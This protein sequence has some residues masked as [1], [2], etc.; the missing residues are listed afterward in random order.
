MQ[1][2]L[3][4]VSDRLRLADQLICRRRAEESLNAQSASAWEALLAVD[5][6]ARRLR[7]HK[8]AEANRRRILE[9]AFDLLRVE[10]LVWVA[11]Q[12]DQPVLVRG[13]ATLSPAEY[14]QLTLSLS[15]FPDFQ[16][17]AP[18]FCN[19]VQGNAW[20]LRYPRRKNVLAF[21]ISDQRPLGWIIAVN[22]QD[23]IPFRKSDAALLTPFAALIELHARSSDRYEDLKDLLVGLTR[24]L[25]TALDAKDSYTYGHSERVARIAVELGREMRLEEEELGDIYLAGLLHDVGK[26]GIRDTVLRKPA[27]LTPEEKE[28]IQQHVNIGYSIL[29]NLRQ[30]RNLLPGVLYHHERI[31]GKGYPDGLAGENIPLMARILAVADAY[32][33]MSNARP[34]RDALTCRR[35][36]E[37][38]TQGAGSQ[39]DARVVEAFMRCRQKIH[40]IRLRGLGDSLQTAIEGALRSQS[41]DLIDADSPAGVRL[42]VTSLAD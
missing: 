31:D 1:N 33:A 42:A 9:V 35:V 20:G 15:Q 21:V 13:E 17:S 40:T 3:R 10:A 23:G 36:E 39:W 32:D 12:A 5:Q 2:W 29:A 26:I 24:S 11:Q 34:Y 8:D 37:I 22:K 6:L 28:H 7:I 16:S 4:S 14:R 27:S 18:L 38:L 25:A 19:N 41:E 30:I